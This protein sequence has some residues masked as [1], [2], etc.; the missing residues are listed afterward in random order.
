MT[1]RFGSGVGSARIVARGLAAGLIVSA[2][3]AGLLGGCTSSSASAAASAAGTASPDVSVDASIVSAEPT[4]TKFVPSQTP[5]EEPTP[6]P[7]PTATPLPNLTGDTPT[8]DPDPPTCNV[9]FVLDI[10]VRNRGR[11]PT[12]GSALVIA[13]ATRNSDGRIDLKTPMPELPPLAAGASIH[14]TKTVRITGGGPHTLTIFIDSS[15]WVAE[16]SEADNEISRA[17]NVLYGA[18]HK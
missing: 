1:S 18:C 11:G 8:L 2:F 17:V 4:R 13:G 7:V 14:L 16:T 10:V 6:T 12:L 9:D 5:T 15:L 3:A